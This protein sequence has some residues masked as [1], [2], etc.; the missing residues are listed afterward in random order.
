MKQIM[1]AILGNL[2][3]AVPFGTVAA[4][5]SDDLQWLEDPHGELALNWAREAT[6]RT[7]TQLSALPSHTAIAEELKTTLAQAPAEAEQLLL[8]DRMVRLHRDA[9]HPYGL[10][11]TAP[12]KRA[13]SSKPW[14]LVEATSEALQGMGR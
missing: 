13:R 8:G 14:L 7:R 10:L 12:R 4:Q 6:A 11:Q 2:A 3:L 9:A 1:H 5:T